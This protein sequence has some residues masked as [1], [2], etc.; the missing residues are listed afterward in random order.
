MSDVLHLPIR[1][2]CLRRIQVQTTFRSRSPAPVA[3]RCE[4]ACLSEVG[5]HTVFSSMRSARLENIALDGV[6]E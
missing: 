6:N 2:Y 1:L 3:L 4:L 5:V